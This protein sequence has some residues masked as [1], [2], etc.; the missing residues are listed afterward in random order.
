MFQNY[1]RSFEKN[2]DTTTHNIVIL[3]FEHKASTFTF[4]SSC[5]TSLSIPVTFSDS[6]TAFGAAPPSKKTYEV[7]SFVG[8]V[9]RGGSCNCDVISYIPHCH[10]TH[11]ECVGH[12]LGHSVFVPDVLKQ[13]FFISQVVTVNCSKSMTIS[14]KEI[15]KTALLD[16]VQALI[17]RTLPNDVNKKHAHY[18]DQAPYLTPDAVEWMNEKNIEHIVVDF[19][20][21]DPMWDA[22]NL[23][24]HRTFWNLSEKQNEPDGKTWLNKTVTELA[25]IPANIEDGHYLM[26]LQTF[27][28]MLDAVP[29][30]PV[31]YQLLKGNK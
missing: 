30:K 10:G 21:L 13:S 8:S 7:G 23:S 14:R 5:G 19:P 15:E 11:T 18:N 17:I 26:D 1:P 31:I 28:F 22:G 20:S 6:V 9:R 2:W 4:D 12:L 25:Y 29:S 3:T 24:A 16:H 27:D